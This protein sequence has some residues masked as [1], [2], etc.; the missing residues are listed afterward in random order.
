M[1]YG[2]TVQKI[3]VLI[4]GMLLLNESNMQWE[5]YLLGV[6][7]LLDFVHRPVFQGTQNNTMFRK[8]D[9]FPSSDKGVGYNY[10][11][12]S[13]RKSEPQSQEAYTVSETLC[14]LVLF[15]LP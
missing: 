14:P 10:S 12:G 5:C 11:I 1:L 6:T 9:L 2:V 8:L 3:T 7:G 4:Y 13:V 15:R